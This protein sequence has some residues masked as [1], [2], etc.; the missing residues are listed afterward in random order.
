MSGAQELMAAR[1]LPLVNIV[2]GQTVKL[3][4]S[5][6]AV[7]LQLFDSLGN[8]VGTKD[9]KLAYVGLEYTQGGDEAVD[10]T[11]AAALDASAGRVK[12][13]LD[14]LGDKLR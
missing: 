13:S 4:Q 10:A 1:T 12:L 3:G 5:G 9:S 7:S 6:Q 11:S 14:K 8:A 2:S